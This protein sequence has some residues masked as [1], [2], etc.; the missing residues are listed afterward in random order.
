MIS[1]ALVAVRACFRVHRRS[2]RTNTDGPPGSSVNPW[3]LLAGIH[4]EERW[5]N[6]LGLEESCEGDFATAT[7]TKHCGVREDLNVVPSI[8]G[9]AKFTGQ[10]CLNLSLQRKRFII[11][12]FG[13]TPGTARSLIG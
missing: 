9:C 6:E 8:S 5:Y 10:I 4:G 1:V 2:T 7:S 11:N 13:R 12:Q 3:R